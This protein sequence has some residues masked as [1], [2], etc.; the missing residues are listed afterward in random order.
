MQWFGE[1]WGAPVCDPA[2]HV[3]TP[4]DLQCPYCPKQID[5]GDQGFL[6][7]FISDETGVTVLA[8]H[9]NCLLR[10]ILPEGYTSARRPPV[11]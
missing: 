9:R 4:V 1:S 7:P 2:D 6:L 11:P 3:D 5:E 8:F 10:S